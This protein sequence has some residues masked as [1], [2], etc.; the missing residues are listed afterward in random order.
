MGPKPDNSHFLQS[1]IDLKW[2]MSQTAHSGELLLKPSWH[3]IS[4]APVLGHPLLTQVYIL[5]HM[6]K[7]VL[8]LGLHDAELAS[9]QFRT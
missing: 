9:V 4:S 6:H 5:V 8:F 1:R 7:P 3:F 2:P